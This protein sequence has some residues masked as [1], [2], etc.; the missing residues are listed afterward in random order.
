MQFKIT[1]IAMLASLCAAQDLSGL[2]ACSQPCFINA[3]PDSGCSDP[4]D[5]ACL[6]ASS[7]FNNEVTLCT[8]GACGAADQIATITW[9]QA[10]C[11]AAG[12]PL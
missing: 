6:C 4:T 8:L 1:I 5:Y 11:E 7:T 9:A 3:F 2:P 12:V 10:T